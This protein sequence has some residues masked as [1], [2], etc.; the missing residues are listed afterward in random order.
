M[1]GIWYGAK[2]P[3][4]N[5]HLSPM[6][7][8]DMPRASTYA[9]RFRPLEM[10]D[11]GR[12]IFQRPDGRISHGDRSG[13]S[14]LRRTEDGSPNSSATPRLVP[15]IFIQP[16]KKRLAA[17]LARATART[18]GVAVHLPA[19]RLKPVPFAARSKRPN[20]P[21]LRASACYARAHPPARPRPIR[22]QPG[23]TAG[24]DIHAA[25][26]AHRRPH[27]TGG[28]SRRRGQPHIRARGAS[29][30]CRRPGT[31]RAQAGTGRANLEAKGTSHKA[32]Q[33]RRPKHAQRLPELRPHLL[34]PEPFQ[35][36]RER[37]TLRQIQ[38]SAYHRHLQTAEPGHNRF[39]GPPV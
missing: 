11:T 6:F 4:F 27:E 20:V 35:D 17:S 22:A 26:P 19:V 23:H 3:L 13:H 16:K 25:Q 38:G 9:M 15:E 2:V 18:N 39:Q 12:G 32:F 24:R 7:I 30:A 14:V 31:C 28:S 5:G 36:R 21:H 37:S 34:Q 1:G 33:A 10:G 29:P 8:P